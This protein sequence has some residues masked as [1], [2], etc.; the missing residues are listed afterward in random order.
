MLEAAPM[1]LRLF[2]CMLRLKTRDQAISTIF[3][4]E[5][6]QGTLPLDQYRAFQA[7]DAV[8]FQ[9]VATLCGNAAQEILKRNNFGFA[10]FYSKQSAKIL[11]LHKDFV[12]EKKPKGLDMDSVGKA[13]QSYMRFQ[14]QVEPE[15]LAMA[16]LPCS[17]LYAELEKTEVQNSMGNVYE[18]D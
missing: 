13:L 2:N 5:M 7:E 8:Y 15:R 9:S 1:S 18:K 12:D 16:M 6:A 4:T 17:M 14:S 3:I 10:D 11:K